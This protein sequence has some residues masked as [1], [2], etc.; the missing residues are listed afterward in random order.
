[1]PDGLEIWAACQ[2]SGTHLN[3]VQQGQLWSSHA[4]GI[5]QDDYTVMV[6]EEGVVYCG[7]VD[8]ALREVCS[9]CLD[10]RV[11]EDERLL[12]LNGTS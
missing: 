2:A 10:T 3:V 5:D 1:M 9:W 6:L 7:W 12:S 4:E 8:A 11:Q